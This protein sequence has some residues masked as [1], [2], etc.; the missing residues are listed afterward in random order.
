MKRLFYKLLNE[1]FEEHN[2]DY[3]YNVDY[4]IHY[5]ESREIAQKI[6]DKIGKDRLKKYWF[7]VE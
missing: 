6:V 4:G 1:I 2:F 7:G 3:I 5:F